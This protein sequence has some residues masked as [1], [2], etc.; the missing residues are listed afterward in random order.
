MDAIETG[1]EFSQ[2]TLEFTSLL[3]KHNVCISASR[4]SL[5]VVRPL[6]KTRKKSVGSDITDDDNNEEEDMNE[7]DSETAT[8]ISEAASITDNNND[9]NFY[10]TKLCA[11]FEVS[12]GQ[13]NCHYCWIGVCR[14]TQI[15]LF[16]TG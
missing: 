6:F 15:R 13:K 7:S 14:V 10:K 16:S 11:R 9:N 4:V 2:P 1:N 3:T 5:S 12:L 8:T